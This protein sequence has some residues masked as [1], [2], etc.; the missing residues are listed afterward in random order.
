MEY[1]VKKLN[2]ELVKL[3][4]E[5][6]FE[7]LS[8]DEMRRLGV[9]DFLSKYTEYDEES[10]DTYINSSA[11]R[12]LIDDIMTEP[13]EFPES[14]LDDLQNALGS[15]YDEL[16]NQELSWVNFIDEE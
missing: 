13:D 4:E 3:K 9:W 14:I 1:D 11:F 12:D 6:K 5:S 2:E 10:G 8:K 7:D 16:L 15:C